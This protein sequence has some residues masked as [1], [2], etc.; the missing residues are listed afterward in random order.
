MKNG[1]EVKHYTVE[2]KS[3]DDTGPNANK[4]KL[5]AYFKRYEQEMLQIRTNIEILKH[6]KDSPDDI[7]ILVNYAPCFVKTAWLNMWRTAVVGMGSILVNRKTEQTSMFK[8][9]E[10]VE[11]NQKSIFTREF[12][13]RFIPDDMGIDNEIEWIKEER[14]PLSCVIFRCQELLNAQKLDI[15]KLL[16]LRDKLYAHFDEKSLES[17]FQKNLLGDVNVDLLDQLA[18]VIQEVYNLIHV[19]YDNSTMSLTYSNCDDIVVLES[20]VRRYD[21][22]KADILE[23]ERERLL[24]ETTER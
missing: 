7:E 13:E 10:Y 3:V 14:E 1:F 6:Y 22:Y 24:T 12:Y 8:F 11:T 5:E 21:Q 4:R 16:A 15:E 20:V 17:D 9:L 2:H 18:H 19:Q 23:L